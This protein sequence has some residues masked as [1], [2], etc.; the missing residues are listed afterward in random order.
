M[1]APETGDLHISKY[2]FDGAIIQ[3]QPPQTED[4]LLSAL[5]ECNSQSSMKMVTK[6][7]GEHQAIV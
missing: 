2:M 5:A 7:R 3:L 6:A 4:M 1:F